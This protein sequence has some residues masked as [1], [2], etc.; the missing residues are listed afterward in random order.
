[1]KTI[2]IFVFGNKKVSQHFAQQ[3]SVEVQRLFSSSGS[4]VPFN[5]WISFINQPTII[6]NK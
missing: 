4:Y 3:V 1:M 6:R 2:F 5:W